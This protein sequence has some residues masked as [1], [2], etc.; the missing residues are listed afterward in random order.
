MSVEKNMKI[1]KKFVT[2]KTLEQLST[3]T[4]KGKIKIKPMW[5]N[6]F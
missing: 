5:F 6:S 4:F 3:L 2:D 1:K